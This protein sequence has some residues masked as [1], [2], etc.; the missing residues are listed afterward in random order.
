MRILL[1]LRA[2]AN[3]QNDRMEDGT[4]LIGRTRS[5]TVKQQSQFEATK[6]IKRMIVKILVLE[7]IFKWPRK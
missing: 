6:T 4:I 5:Y 2:D 3:H 1:N 7:R